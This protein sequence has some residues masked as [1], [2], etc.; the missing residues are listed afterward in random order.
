MTLIR[1]S[2]DRKVIT[3]AQL[4]SAWPERAEFR[5]RI[6]ESPV[7]TEAFHPAMVRNRGT[8]SGR[9]V[10]SRHVRRTDTPANDIFTPASGHARQW[11][12][13]PVAII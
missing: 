1:P 11:S 13:G 2:G 4:V 8:G 7:R 9:Y 3:V 12:P 6:A 10:S 5:P